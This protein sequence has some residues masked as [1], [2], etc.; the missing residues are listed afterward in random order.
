M[1]LPAPNLI[2]QD[3]RTLELTYG[4]IE[5]RRLGLSLGI[6]PL[7]DIKICSFDCPYCH[8]GPSQ[9]RMNQIKK[10]VT[11]PSVESIETSLREKLRELSSQQVAINTLT[12]SGNGEPTLYPY[13][14]ELTERLLIVRDELSSDTPVVVLTNG[15]HIDSRRMVHALDLYDERMI[16][17]DAGSE[18][19]FKKMNN[20]LIRAS[21]SKVINGARK[22]RNCVVQSLFVQGSIDNTRDQS[23]DEWMEVVGLIFPRSVHLYTLKNPGHVAGLTPASEDTLYTIASK[24]KR[25]TQLE[26]KVFT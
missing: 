9:V 18:S 7:G 23:L 16:K 2:H 25:R 19:D 15:A 21:I 10:D 5:S 11:F 8:L 3:T 13:F 20:P 6:N 14:A 12:V 1:S 26:A 24:L 4:P 17:I 22:L